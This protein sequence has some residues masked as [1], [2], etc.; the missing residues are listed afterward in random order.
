MDDQFST[1]QSDLLDDARQQLRAITQLIAERATLTASATVRKRVTVTVNAD[2]I[3]IETK[4]G[5]GIEEL[6]PP[7]IAAAVTEAGQL[8]CT[9]MARKSSELMAPAVLDSQR[10]PKL[11]GMVEDIP[12][13]P[14][15]QP[16]AASTAPPNS[17]ER[18]LG[19]HPDPGMHFAETENYPRATGNSATDSAW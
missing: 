6:S 13:L 2:N 10:L 19:S 14:I 4:F 18:H 3:I 17:P 12:D 8:A 16:V 9:A 5:P 1:R 15:P 7:E 11:T